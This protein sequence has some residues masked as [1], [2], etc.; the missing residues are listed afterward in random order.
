MHSQERH[1][2]IGTPQS[3]EVPGSLCVLGSA[4][5]YAP[6]GGLLHRRAA[7]VA[8]QVLVLFGH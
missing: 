3:A 5:T 7:G 4:M 8:Y 6:T 1:D 2:L